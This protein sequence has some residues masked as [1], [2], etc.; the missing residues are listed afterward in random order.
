MDMLCS[1]KTGILTLNKMTLQERVPFGSTSPKD[2]LL[3]AMLGTRWEEQAN[4]TIDTMLFAERAEVDAE[5]VKYQSVDYGPFDPAIKRTAGTMQL[6]ADRKTQFKVTKG[7]PN[8]IA[9]LSGSAGIEEK[10]T[11]YL[12]EY[13]W[14]GIR[15]LGIARSDAS[16]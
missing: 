12:D 9:A 11:Q 7:A 13:V 4:D 15:C 1:D 14:R 5:L 10:V 8:V 6:K 3:H 2:L 16:G